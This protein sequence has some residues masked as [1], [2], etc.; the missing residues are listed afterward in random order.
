MSRCRQSQDS[1]IAPLLRNLGWWCAPVLRALQWSAIAGCFGEK[2]A[3]PE[4]TIQ[5]HLLLP[6]GAWLTHSF[7]FPH[8]PCSPG[9]GFGG[10]EH[11]GHGAGQRRYC[12]KIDTKRQ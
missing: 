5:T 9:P 7:R 10:P 4:N 3:L 12:H 6:E 8:T 1:R 11:N 2:S